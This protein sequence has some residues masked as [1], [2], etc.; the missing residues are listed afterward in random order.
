[1]NLKLFFIIPVLAATC[2][3]GDA[4]PDSTPAA[5]SLSLPV[6]AKFDAAGTWKTQST[7][8]ASLPVLTQFENT[9]QAVSGNV[10]TF[11]VPFAMV[12]NLGVTASEGTLDTQ[13]GAYTLCYTSSLSDCGV[14]CTGTVDAS[15]HV[16]LAC[17]VIATNG[18]CTID[19]QK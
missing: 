2:A 12:G 16:T 10:Q 19:L 18:A 15:N 5:A 1:M 14:Q 6:G 7:T 9:I 4:T 13:T 8:C 17:N 11:A 3:C